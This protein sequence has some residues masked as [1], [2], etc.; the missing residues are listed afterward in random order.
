MQ[1]GIYFPE[2]C[3]QIYQILQIINYNGHFRKF[4]TLNGFKFNISHFVIFVEI[5]SN[6]KVATQFVSKLSGCFVVLPGFE[7]GQTEPKTVVLPLHHKTIL[8]PKNA[9]CLLTLRR[10]A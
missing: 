4:Y 1:R 6:R 3:I 2:M 9:L 8:R 5:G 10:R 7:P